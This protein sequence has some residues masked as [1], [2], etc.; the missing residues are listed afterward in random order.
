M[1]L[2]DN[3]LNVS[4]KFSSENSV[5][6]SFNLYKSRVFSRSFHQFFCALSNE[7]MTRIKLLTLGILIVCCSIKDV[8]SE[9]T[10]E[11]MAKASNLMKQA[12]LPKFKI[13]ESK[14]WFSISSSSKISLKEISDILEDT[15]K[16]IFAEDRQLKCYINCMLEMMQI[17]KKGKLNYQGAMKQVDTLVPNDMKDDFRRGIEACKDVASSIKDHCESSFAVIK[18]Y[19]E[20]NPKFLIPWSI[21]RWMLVEKWP[22]TSNYSQF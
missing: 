15:K 17:M 2:H 13:P 10:M 1:H 6:S 3:A 9:V 18:C 11:D 8:K 16:N 4:I 14:L 5:I 20:N 7:N 21:L 19:V 12:C 22:T